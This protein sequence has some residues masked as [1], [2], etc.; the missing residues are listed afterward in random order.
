MFCNKENVNMLT[1]LL[2][3]HGVCNAV[4][5]PGSRNAPIVHNLY[6]LEQ[7]GLMHCHPV[8]DE[9]SAGFYAIGIAQATGM[10]AAVCVTSGSALLNIAPAAAEAKYQHIPLIIIS[11]D[12]PAAW[13]DQLDGQTLP[14]PDALAG[15][16]RKHVSLPEPHTDEERW[17]CNRMI[18]EALLSCRRCP[19]APVHINIPLTEPLFKFSTEQLPDERKI[20][21][22]T[23]VATGCPKELITALQHAER[24]ML[25]IGQTKNDRQLQDTADDLRRIITVIQEPLSGTAVRF[26]EALKTIHNDSVYLPD[27]II[28]T[29]DTIVSKSMRK[30]LRMAVK[31]E[32]WRLSEDGAV[33]DC[34]GHLTHIVEGNPTEILRT[35]SQNSKPNEK[36]AAYR[37]IWESIIQKSETDSSDEDMPYSAQLAVKTFEQQIAQ[38]KYKFAVHYANSTSIRL[39]CT[40]AEHFVYCNRGINGI[41]GSLSTAAGFSSVTDRHVF[42]I[43]GDLS[44]FYDCNALWNTRLRGNFRIL[45]LNDGG[46]S[47]FH[48]LPGADMSPALNEYIAGSHHT[49][50]Y[51]ICTAH[52]ITYI[53]ATD[54]KE[55]EAAIN[56]LIH[57]RESRRPI[58]AEILLPGHNAYNNHTGL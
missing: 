45:L 48:S 8:T 29:G 20:E 17:H 2:V 7:R 6:E 41:E 49:S 12:R 36:A 1:A 9:R 43:T 19:G 24:P 3:K 38:V 54:I 39:A 22:L 44:F 11:A 58:V 47:I 5:C 10:P 26:E 35:L 31:A 23:Q 52:N 28:Y 30:F 32:Q 55:T 15:I 53:Q 18:N 40:F 13:I 46:G 50:A 56:R 57:D 27:L 51:G 25:V 21:L 14:Q 4:V 33:E 16:L 37:K 34:F 42:C